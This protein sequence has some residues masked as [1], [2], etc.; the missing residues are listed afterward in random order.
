MDGKVAT[1]PPATKSDAVQKFLS[2]A[3]D[4]AVLKVR[5]NADNGLDA[6]RSREMGAVGIGLCRTEHMFFQAD[7]LRAMRQMLLSRDDESRH[8]ALQKIL[9]IQR[10]EFKDIFRSMNGLP[11][12]IRLLDPPLHEFL[13]KR[14][15]D[16]VLLAKDLGLRDGALKERLSQLHE[17]NP[18]S[19]HNRRAL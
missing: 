14:E 6:T 4:F 2:W 16:I 13:P 10:E 15:E 9:P 11:V 7:A 8:R 1:L 17:M 18:M 12:T 3:D 5:A 19:E